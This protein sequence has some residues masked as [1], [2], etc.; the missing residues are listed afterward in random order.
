MYRGLAACQWKLN[1][2]DYLNS[3]HSEIDKSEASAV[4]GPA[5]VK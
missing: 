1:V 2:Q 3:V 5:G 4:H